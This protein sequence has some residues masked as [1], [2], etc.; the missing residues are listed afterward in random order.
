MLGRNASQKSLN[1]LPCFQYDAP[2]SVT[3]VEPSRVRGKACFWVQLIRSEMTRTERDNTV[4]GRPYSEVSCDVES[5]RIVKMNTIVSASGRAVTSY[6]T[7]I[8][9]SWLMR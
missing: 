4:H 9:R 7:A 3:A 2:P 5:H 1:V 6:G 8:A